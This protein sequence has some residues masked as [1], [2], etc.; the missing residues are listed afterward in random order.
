[1]RQVPLQ[2][3]IHS[4]F[5]DFLRMFPK[6]DPLTFGHMG[7][8]ICLCTAKGPNKLLVGDLLILSPPQ[9]QGGVV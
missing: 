6:S 4:L 9:M 3:T 8:F 1:M 7:I 5:L 2:I